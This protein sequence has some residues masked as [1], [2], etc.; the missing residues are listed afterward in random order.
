MQTTPCLVQGAVIRNM[1][2]TVAPPPPGAGL[3]QTVWYNLY[4]VLAVVLGQDL[5]PAEQAGW[6]S[7][8]FAIVTAVFGLASFALVL[9]LIEQVG[10]G[11][12]WGGLGGGTAVCAWGWFYMPLWWHGGI[13]GGLALLPC[14]W[15]PRRQ[16]ALPCAAAAAPGTTGGCRVPLRPFA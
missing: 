11:V 12:G 4:K 9:A 5:P 6:P 1:D 8:L 16:L 2:S 10:G 3:L 15:A 14:V 13:H 7:Q